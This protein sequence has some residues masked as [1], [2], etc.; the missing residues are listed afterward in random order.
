MSGV[1]RVILIDDHALF[2]DS[3]AAALSQ[4]PD[5]TVAGAFASPDEAIEVIRQQ[6][7]DLVLL[8]INLG[9]EQ[10]GSFLVR[11]R[12]IGYK[13][14]ILAVTAGVSE[15][16]A[17]WLLRR[18][19][20]GIFLKNDPVGFLFDRMRHVMSTATPPMDSVSV[21]AIV[22]ELENQPQAASTR[23]TTRERQV[24]RLVCKGLANK[25]IASDLAVTEHT[26]KA[27]VRQL[28]QKIGVRSRAQL[29]CVAIEEYWEELDG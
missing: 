9:A 11:A 5:F 12:A 7:V 17:A 15:R 14:K 25:E 3:L 1:T 23:L 27:F 4:E 24:L 16:E 21:R 2:R 22:A 29:V 10:G 19:C 13:G 8:D 26:V 6:N 20:S 28:F 18:G